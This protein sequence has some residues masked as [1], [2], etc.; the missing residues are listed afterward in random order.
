MKSVLFVCLGNICRSPTAEGVVRKL[1]RESDPALELDLDSAGT[2]TYHLGDP[3]DKRAQQAAQQRGIDI[4]EHRGRA[5]TPADFE[6]FDYILAMDR[7]N[8]D[9]LQAMQPTDSKATLKRLLEFAANPDVLDVP[10]PYFGGHNG[11]KH[12]LD[13]IEAAARGLLKRLSAEQALEDNRT[14]ADS[15]GRMR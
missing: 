14:A 11:F 5:V 2:H 15:L 1:A 13:L 8:L 9:D 6:H 7:Q 12:V 10:D 4:S 3:P